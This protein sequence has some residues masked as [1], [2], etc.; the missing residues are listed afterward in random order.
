M[1]AVIMA[2]GEGCRLRPLTCNL[3]KPMAKIIGKPIIEFIFDV[4]YSCGVTTVAV[5]L[6]YLP[7]IIEERY[8][9]GYKNLN[10]EFVREDEPLGT[11]GCVKNAAVAYNEPFLVISGD[12]FCDFD[13]KKIMAYHKACGAKITIV[14]TD[15]SGLHEYGT[16]KVNEE[17]RVVGFDETPS[18]NQTDGSLA[19]AGV[20]I[21]NPECLELIPKGEKY[22]FVTDLF[23]LM[24]ERD[25]P[26]YCYYTKEYWCDVN[27]VESYLKCQRDVFDGRMKSPIGLIADGI[28]VKST[29]P[30]GD[31]SVIPPVYIGENTEISDGAVIGPYAVIDDNCF[32]GENAKIR[33]SAV[34]ENSCIACGS[35]VTGALTCSGA[36]LKNQSSMLENSVA[37]SGCIIGENASVKSS[38]RIWPG[39]IVRS[40]EIVDSDVKFRK[41]KTMHII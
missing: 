18:R 11:A 38:V 41:I 13:V 35:A 21:I 30:C 14:C 10:L 40:G 34:L 32:I 36:V 2:G 6:G 39:K 26:I 37:G 3:P 20:Y 15:I 16:V 17:N 27:D 28:Y 23:P 25:M 7:H 31:Y 22:D 1:K 8:E 4:L 29:M 19:N 5:T 9:S 33:Y 12:A 24:L